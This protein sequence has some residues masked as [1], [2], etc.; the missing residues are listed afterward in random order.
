M[1]IEGRGSSG[2]ALGRARG[3]EVLVGLFGKGGE[4]RAFMRRGAG[5][6]DEPRRVLAN[7]CG[8]AVGPRKLKPADAVFDSTRVTGGALGRKCLRLVEGCPCTL[9]VRRVGRQRQV[10][11]EQQQ[12]EP[13]A[14][15]SIATDLRQCFAQRGG[16]RLGEWRRSPFSRGQP[17]PPLM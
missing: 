17:D 7:R 6:P 8:I 11:T 15:I 5:L 2:R 3:M 14:G 12:I 4:A 13:A 9:T 16:K 10:D 1:N